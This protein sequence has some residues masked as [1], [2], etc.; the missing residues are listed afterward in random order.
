MKRVHAIVLSTLLPLVP[1]GHALGQ[2]IGLG[3]RGGVSVTDFKSELGEFGNKVGISF[4]VFAPVSFGA[5]F[6][7]LPELQFI[8]KGSE[9]EMPDSG[10]QASLEST[11][12]DV[13]IGYMS[14]LVPA[15]LT[16]PL[17]EKVKP[18]LYVGPSLALELTCN[19]AFRVGDIV[20]QAGCGRTIGDETAF[21]RTTTFDFGLVFGGGVDVVAGPGAFTGDVRYTQGLTNINSEGEPNV[22]NRALEFLIGYTITLTE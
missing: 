15:A 19:V 14:L 9:N 17:A 12:V 6:A 20:S 18:R 10:E 8:N 4:G 3:L 7:I 21:V 1:P 16:I 2:E 5:W 13:Q 22:K 11:D